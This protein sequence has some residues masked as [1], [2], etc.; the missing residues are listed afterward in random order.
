MAAATVESL[1]FDPKVLLISEVVALNPP[2]DLLESI[3]LDDKQKWAFSNMYVYAGAD[4][5][6]E[7]A[8][9][10][11]PSLYNFKQI[12]NMWLIF[13]PIILATFILS[14]QFF[15]YMPG[16][17]TRYRAFRKDERLV[18]IFHFV[19]ALAFA[20]KIVPQTIWTIQLLF[21]PSF[22]VQFNN[23][24][25]RLWGCAITN[26]LLYV[27]E[28]IARSV[29]RVN[30]F[31]L[32]HHILYYIFFIVPVVRCSVW[33]SKLILML[34][35]FIVLCELPLYLSLLAH[36]FIISTRKV[37]VVTWVCMLW[38]A[39]LRVLELVILIAYFA[40]TYKRMQAW[41]ET[42]MWG[43][44]LAL[45]IPGGAITVIFSFGIFFWF[46]MKRDRYPEKY[47]AA[48]YGL[49]E[50]GHAATPASRQSIHLGSLPEKLDP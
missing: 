13:C 18:A 49:P 14:S 28:G 9:N 1:P 43:W 17:K 7:A 44:F 15:R 21:G 19:F 8:L 37:K 5:T 22:A 46:L 24:Y 40:G 26:A 3:L 31:L 25:K 23:N 36:R 39:A 41:G 10:S 12:G 6:M 16:L 30:P 33:G 42:Q 11:S 20:A 45:S 38:S 2:A 35:C 32:A 48:R 27:A 47:G 34:D 29:I 50:R 4:V